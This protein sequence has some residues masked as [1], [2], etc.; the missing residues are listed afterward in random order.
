[1]AKLRKMLGDVNSAVCTDIMA[2]IAT[3]SQ[4][5]IEKW[6]VEYAAGNVLPVY[7]KDC[8]GETL[9]AETVENAAVIC[10]AG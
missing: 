2:L 3:Q 5:T 4:Q 9:L 10:R 7:E 8:P 1:M 6:A